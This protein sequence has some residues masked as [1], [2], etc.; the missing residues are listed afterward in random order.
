MALL[1]ATAL[2]GCGGTTSED[3]APPPVTVET[4][5]APSGRPAAP[6]LTG[7]SLEGERISLEGFRGRPVLVNVWSSW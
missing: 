7:T 3:A 5:T 2:T 6:A 4:T 1:V